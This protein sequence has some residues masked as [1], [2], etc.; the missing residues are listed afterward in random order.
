[1]DMHMTTHSAQET[2]RLGYKLGVLLKTKEKAAAVC[3]FG[4]LGAGKTTFVKGFATAFGVPAREIG[5]ASFI[6]VAEY[7]TSPPFYHIDLYRL[8]SELCA[9]D[10]G[11]WEYIESDGIAVIE[12]AEK[13]G[14][15]PDS[16]IRV[17]LRHVDEEVR[18][19]TIAGIDAKEM[20]ALA[21]VRG[22]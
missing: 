14:E 15:L 5:S 1:M 9:E 6:I 19:I 20:D 2:E 8:A 22:A 10:M 13:L 16:A 3:L 7:D 4:D 17:T 12:W 21:G 18:D 11:I